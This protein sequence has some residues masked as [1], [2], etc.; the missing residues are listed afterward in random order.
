MP[1][2][3]LVTASTGAKK[4]DG[5]KLRFDLIPASAELALAEVLT[6]GA[7]KYDDENWRKGF[8]W[9]R[10]YAA[11]R[12]HMNSWINPRESD[13]DSETNLNHLKHAFCCLAFLIEYLE[14]HPELDNRVIDEK[15]SV[16]SP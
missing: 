16:M 8:P 3:I 2:D 1:Q 7:A 6:F 11:A 13:Y 12:R 4:A 10:V 14:S 5:G 15:T 9:K